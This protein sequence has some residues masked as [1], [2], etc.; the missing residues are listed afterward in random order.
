M[1]HFSL[2]IPRLSFTFPFSYFF[3][4]QIPQTPQLSSLSL[5][6]L[7][8]GSFR[9]PLTAYL[10]SS[11]AFYL[12]LLLSSIPHIASSSFSPH[13]SFLSP[14]SH[15]SSLPISSTVLHPF[16]ISSTLLLS[17]LSLLLPTSP[18]LP[19]YYHV[20]HIYAIP[21]HNTQ[22]SRVSLLS[23]TLPRFVFILHVEP[24]CSFLAPAPVTGFLSFPRPR[25]APPL[26]VSQPCDT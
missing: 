14:F 17:L 6:Q 3:F 25:P 5:P 16:P 24:P 21:S 2:S 1:C 11:I 20:P 18:S 22:P 19:H 4:F 8:F 10:P 26:P 13:P 12:S 7:F 15:S 9:V 23:F